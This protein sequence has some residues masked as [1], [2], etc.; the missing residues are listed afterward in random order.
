[1]HLLANSTINEVVLGMTALVLLCGSAGLLLVW[2]NSPLLRGLGPLAGSFAF[3]GSGALLM[4]LNH[5]LPGWLTAQGAGLL[6]LLCFVALHNA[7]LAVSGEANRFDRLSLF[8]VL[9]QIGLGALT[10]HPLAS[11]KYLL[12]GHSF[13]IATRATVTGLTLLRSRRQTSQ[14]PAVLCAAL[15]LAYAFLLLLRAA[16]TAVG[17]LQNPLA[18][19]GVEVF[20]SVVML[21]AVLGI[22]FGFFWM[23]TSTFASGLERMASTDPLTRIFNRRSFLLWCEKERQRSLASGTPF[24]LLLLDLD[25][26]KRV[27]DTFGHPVGDRLL[28]AVVENVQD[29]IRGIDVLG[30]WGGEEFAVLLPRATPEAA[31]LV[32]ERVRKNIQR[33]T[34]PLLASEGH[35]A[36]TLST[37]ASFGTA[38]FSGEND[39]IDA[40]LQRADAALYGA[41][42][43]G[44]NRTVNAHELPQPQTA[45]ALS[46]LWEVPQGAL[47]ATAESASQVGV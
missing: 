47:H 17:L 18:A 2:H 13:L 26:F 20:T 30:R 8:L 9:L 46:P 41:K 15:L 5:W 4:A 32:A 37:T 25:H 24:S 38:T 40:M 7:V 36:K 45:E 14:T 29:G 31:F 44:R 1:M 21:A 22:V 43:G 3:G 28:C 16:A 11:L 33:L 35:G 6:M 10:V 42:R 23:T 34:M 12:A 39:S 19:A 27:N